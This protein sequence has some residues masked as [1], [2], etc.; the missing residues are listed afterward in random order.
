MKY[1]ALLRGVNV[2]GKNKVSMPELRQ[3]FEDI[4]FGNVVTHINSGNVIFD[5][6]KLAK[7]KLVIKCEDAIEKQFGFHVICSVITATELQDALKNAPPWWGE[8]PDTKHDAFFAIAPAT[9]KSIM[10]EVGQHN[11]EYEKVTSWGPIIFWSAPLKTFGRTKYGKI[12]GTKA[13]RSVTIRNSNSTRK[14][15]A[16]TLTD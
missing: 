12:A 15:V 6:R 10:D 1:V 3:C 4:G 13:Y 14:L 11:S 5:F 7:E 16:L 2:G 8:S 9:A